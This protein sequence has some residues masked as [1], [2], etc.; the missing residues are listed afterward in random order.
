[1]ML[2]EELPRQIPDK[3][4]AC[5]SSITVIQRESAVSSRT[6]PDHVEGLQELDVHTLGPPGPIDGAR[7]V[8]LV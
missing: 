5:C 8:V 4:A 3:D 2:A 1:M 6:P 7:S